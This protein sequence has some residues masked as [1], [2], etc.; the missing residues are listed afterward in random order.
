MIFIMSFSQIGQ[1]LEVVEFY[2]NKSNGFFV[3]IGANDGI[4]LS[5][6]YLL[7][8]FTIGLESV[9][10]LFRKILNYCIK[11]DRNHFVVA[12]LFT[13]KVIK[14]LFLISRMILYF[15]VSVIVLTVIKI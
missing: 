3:E 9:L 5:N 2:K 12:M 14:K 15:L 6:T 4:T 1:D 7:E 13:G 11:I 8:K 10:N